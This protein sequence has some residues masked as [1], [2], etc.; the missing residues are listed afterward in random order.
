MGKSIYTECSKL[1][2]MGRIFAIILVLLASSVIVSGCTSNNTA[3]MSYGDMKDK[4]SLKNISIGN[5]ESMNNAKEFYLESFV[6]FIDGKPKP[7]FST[8]EI[9]VNKGDKIRLL[10]NTTR[11]THDFNID[12][13]NLH[14]ATPTNKTTIIEF[15]ADKAG[16]FVY[17]CNMP[18][19]RAL[20]HWGTLKVIG[21]Q[22]EN[23]ALENETN[24]TKLADNY[25]RYNTAAFQKAVDGNKTIFL[26]FR[27]NWCPVCQQE[28]PGILDAFNSINYADVIGFEVHYNDNETT[29]FDNNLARKYQVGYQHTKIIIKNGSIKIKTLEFFDKNRV[30]SEI[31]KARSE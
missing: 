28:R 11:G 2:E 8:K 25:Y 15:T 7:Q 12:E 9:V 16:E 27:A 19:H 4:E 1:N 31:E 21:N 20:G 17:Y 24:A 18:N 14:S 3:N 29:D 26:S 23:A 22:T 6:E 13:L 10:I 30:I 5:A